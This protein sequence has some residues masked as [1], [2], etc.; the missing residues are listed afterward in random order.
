MHCWQK[1]FK[2]TKQNKNQSQ[3]K[4]SERFYFLEFKLHFLYVF[5]IPG[6]LL[7]NIQMG[8]RRVRKIKARATN[9]KKKADCQ[10]MGY[11]WVPPVQQASLFLCWAF[12]AAM[13]CPASPF[14][15]PPVLSL[16]SSPLL[17]LGSQTLKLSHGPTSSRCLPRNRSNSLKSHMEPFLSVPFIY[18]TIDN[19]LPCWTFQMCMHAGS[20]VEL[21]GSR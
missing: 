5:S 12:D 14:F 7:E 11:K 10:E 15:F 4:K 13:P 2:K 17:N 20:P 16:P 19:F 1:D 9:R 6:K 21:L 18:F 3:E 8:R